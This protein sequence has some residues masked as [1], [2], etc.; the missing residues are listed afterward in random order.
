M[1]ILSEIGTDMTQ[2]P[3]IKAFVCWLGLCPGN[4]ISGG[5]ILSS[6][7]KPSDNRAARALRMAASTLYRSKTALGA[8][9]RRMRARLGAPKAITATAHKLAR[10]LYRMMTKG[11]DYWEVGENYYEQ[12]YQARV[13]ANL[14]KRA[15]E[16]GYH[17]VLK[18]N[19]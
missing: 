18:A 14:T 16:L 5:K 15:E 13:I 6:K 17:L 2:W 4:K 3:T 7:T 12:Q 19:G 1:K 8:F 11:T 10:I 9:F